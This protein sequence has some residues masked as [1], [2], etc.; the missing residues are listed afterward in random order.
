MIKYQLTILFYRILKKA[1]EIIIIIII[2]YE[3]MPNNA[4]QYNN[5]LTG[6][7]KHYRDYDFTNHNDDMKSSLD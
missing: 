1:S 7:T 5:L 2:I 3:N 4:K 6:E